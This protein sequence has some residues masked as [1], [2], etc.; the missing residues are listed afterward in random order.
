MGISYVPGRK[1]T[2]LD[3]FNLNDIKFSNQRLEA[4]DNDGNL[5]SIGYVRFN[6]VT[7]RNAWTEMDAIKSCTLEF[8]LAG[9]DFFPSDG[10]PNPVNDLAALYNDVVGTIKKA[11]K[12][13]KSAGKYA[14]LTE[15]ELIRSASVLLELDT[16]AYFNN[17]NNP[18]NK[19][20]DPW[21]GY[22]P[23]SYEILAMR[24]LDPK[25]SI[26]GEIAG[27]VSSLGTGN[28]FTIPGAGVNQ[29]RQSGHHDSSGSNELESLKSCIMDL[30]QRVKNL[31]E[32]KIDSLVKLEQRLRK[33]EDAVWS[34]DGPVK[35][36]NQAS[37]APQPATKKQK[38]S[39]GAYAYKIRDISLP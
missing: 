2:S 26:P 39:Y 29:A 18:W 15:T 25:G 30:Q 37:N 10:Q 3:D 24:F 27:M 4:Q 9:L 6:S 1:T 19:D 14:H 35:R 13:M 20:G 12:E 17:R 8:R 33:V 34:K 5:L 31:E 16:I 32:I 21:S 22:L 28:L 7:L 36:P 38:R 23:E 11:M